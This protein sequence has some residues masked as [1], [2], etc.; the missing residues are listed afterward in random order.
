MKVFLSS[1]EIPA[2]YHEYIL[3]RA[4]GKSENSE[5]GGGS[6]YV[7]G[8]ICPLI[9]I[10]LPYLQKSGGGG[11]A[12]PTLPPASDGP[13]LGKCKYVVPIFIMVL[14]TS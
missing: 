2:R 3:F 1:H 8:R 13:G 9:G 12:S 7:V 6:S 5:G 10:R 11:I 14:R 4:V